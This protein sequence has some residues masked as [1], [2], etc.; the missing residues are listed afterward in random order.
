MSEDN[1]RDNNIPENVP[2]NTSDQPREENKEIIQDESQVVSI[3]SDKSKTFLDK[4]KENKKITATVA[5]VVALA[6]CAGITW[7][8][9]KPVEQVRFENVVPERIEGSQ[10]DIIKEKVIPGS[11]RGTI[12]IQDP[13]QNNNPVSAP[14]YAVDATGDDNAATLTVPEDI[15]AVGW[16]GRSA[17][18][19]VDAGST[20]MSSH[21]NYNGITGY[22]SIFL[23]LKPGDPITVTTEDG[24]NWHYVVEQNMAVTKASNNNE[25]QRYIDM[26]SQTINKMDGKN[27]LVLITCSGTYDPTSALGYDQNTVVTAKLVGQD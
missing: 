24:K 23:T 18:P 9:T 3:D 21:I 17:P 12:T 13:L 19:G 5:G 20:V 4:I 1:T 2:D 22:G 27:F 6:L 26:T 15:G 25:K 7:Q 16:Y 11:G 10:G 14:W 8:V